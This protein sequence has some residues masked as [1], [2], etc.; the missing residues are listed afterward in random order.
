VLVNLKHP[1]DPRT[2]YIMRDKVSRDLFRAGMRDPAMQA[3]LAERRKTDPESVQPDGAI[4]AAWAAK[5]WAQPG[6]DAERQLPATLMTVTEAYCFAKWLAGPDG[7]LPTEQQWDKAGGKADGASGPFVDSWK[8]G[9]GGIALDLKSPRP[10]GTSDEDVSLFDCRD[11]AGNG[12]EFTRDVIV[13]G[14]TRAVVPLTRKA[15]YEDSVRL[16]GHI[17]IADQ[18]YRFGDEAEILEYDGPRDDVGFRVVLELP[19]S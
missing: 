17:F 10:V 9:D 5:K 6:S 12:R 16:R 15:T 8:K 11:M 2:F 13:N 1:E 3:L 4:E 18:P 7:N 19:V 14:I